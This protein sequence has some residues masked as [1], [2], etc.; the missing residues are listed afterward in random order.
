MLKIRSGLKI[1]CLTGICFVVFGMAGPVRAAETI[2]PQIPEV[3]WW[4]K[5]SH[6]KISAYVAK[7]HDGDWLPY[8]DKWNKQLAKMKVIYERGGSAVFK[9]QGITIEDKQLLQYIKAIEVRLSAT[10]CLAILDFERAAK[11]LSDME[12]ASGEDEPA[13]KKD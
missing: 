10:R 3:T 9:K 2:C 13:A 4:G 12:T 8:I 7:K 11:Q 6:Q 5:T 1:L